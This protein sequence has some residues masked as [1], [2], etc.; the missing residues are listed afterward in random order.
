M[1]KLK[2]SQSLIWAIEHQNPLDSFPKITT[3]RWVIA[4]SS[5]D[6]SI[7]NNF[8]LRGEILI[9]IFRKLRLNAKKNS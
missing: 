5:C 6:L 9:M 7:F 4:T 2:I 3:E 1:P 8:T